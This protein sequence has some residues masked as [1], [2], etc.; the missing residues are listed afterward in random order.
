MRNN[1]SIRSVGAVFWTIAI[2]FALSLGA[3]VCF[4]QSNDVSF[5]TA[6]TE[7][8]IVGQIKARDIGDPRSTT[9]YFTFNGR[10]GDLFV[11]VV[12]KNLNGSVDIFSVDGMR[13]FANILVYADVLQSETG[14]VLY[15]R[16]PE[17][18]IL[19]IQGRS[20]NDDP[21]DFQIKFAG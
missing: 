16:K 4:G 14:R 19:R 17:K 11:N 21:A 10:Q 2:G 12:T 3:G 13:P 6:L 7:N 15:L 1:T 9:Y 5:P 8:E 18:L 20:P